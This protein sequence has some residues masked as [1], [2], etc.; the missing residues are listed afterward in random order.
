MLM[1]RTR[2]T[3]LGL[4]WV[5]VLHGHIAIAIVVFSAPAEGERGSGR[6]QGLHRIRPRGLGGRGKRL[7]LHLLLGQGRV[8]LGLLRGG[9]SVG[10]VARLASSVWVG[11]GRPLL[12]H[13]SER[14]SGRGDGRGY[15]SRLS[16]EGI[17][18]CASGQRR[19]R[20]RQRR[21]TR[22]SVADRECACGSTMSGRASALKRACVGLDGDGEKGGGGA[23]GCVS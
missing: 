15:D 17:P 16:C 19:R 8:P 3:V 20:L 14:G 22:A 6:G 18:N 23:G 2:C 1:V 10:V 9:H 11:I 13:G 21:V 5:G 4:V 7:L 12:L